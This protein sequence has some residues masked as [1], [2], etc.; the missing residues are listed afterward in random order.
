MLLVDIGCSSKRAPL[1]VSLLLVI[2]TKLAAAILVV[3]VVRRRGS[4]GPVLPLWCVQD[5]DYK[6]VHVAVMICATQVN[7]Q[8]ARMPVC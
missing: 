2:T 7:T 8:A 4:A 5:Y 3:V 1:S 6:S